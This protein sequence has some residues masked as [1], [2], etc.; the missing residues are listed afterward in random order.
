MFVKKITQIIF[1]DQ[2][3]QI[4][5]FFYVIS[6]NILFEYI[7]ASSVFFFVQIFIRVGS[8][9]CHHIVAHLLL[10]VHSLTSLVIYSHAALRSEH[11]RSE[12]R[13]H[14]RLANDRIPSLGWRDF[15]LVVDWNC[16]VDQN[17]VDFK[18]RIGIAATDLSYQSQEVSP[19]KDTSMS[20][21]SGQRRNHNLSWKWIILSL[22]QR[23]SGIKQNNLSM[24]SSHFASISPQFLN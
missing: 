24:V 15:C 4:I 7:W 19:W 22:I 20:W 10:V 1:V 12:C 21:E 3:K 23:F 13:Q 14:D 16:R 8:I 11:I 6:N 18:S 17:P 2:R 9:V 5:F